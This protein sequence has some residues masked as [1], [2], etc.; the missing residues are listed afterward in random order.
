MK[1]RTLI[2]AMP[3]VV[4]L[5]AAAG[6]YLRNGKSDDFQFRTDTVK[7]GNISV[8]VTAT[9]TLSAVIT[10]QVGSQVSGN[11]EKLYADF[12]SRVRR[13]QIVAELDTTF[14][15]AA[16][17]EAEAN[18]QRAKVQLADAK[19]NLDRTTVLFTKN[20]VAQLDLDAARTTYEAAS[21][22]VKQMQAQMDRA[23]VNI[24]YA[25]IRSPIDGVVISRNVD[26][27]QTVAASL[28]APVLFSIANDLTKMQV[29]ASVDE[30]DI[31][32]ISVGLPVT[33]TV[34]AY[35]NEMFT[36]TVS[37]VR[38]AP[39]IVQNVVNYTVI[40]DVPNKDLKLMPGMTANVS[41]LVAERDSVVKVP[42]LA[43]TFRPTQ[44]LIDAGLVNLPH[45]PD[46]GSNGNRSRPDRGGM[47]MQG[48]GFGQGGPGGM[49]GP[50]M[51]GPG[52]G[53]RRQGGI[54][55][56]MDSKG[57][58]NPVPVRTGLSD[59]TSTEIVAGNVKPGDKVVLGVID[60]N[61]TAQ[62]PSQNNPF[63]PQRMGGGGGGR[64]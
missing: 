39:V 5:L 56:V 4:I 32:R 38:L 23:R 47:G 43:L 15:K 11:I 9:G 17:N 37:Q 41:V 58:L 49:Q 6:L 48:R 59:G 18:V 13:G 45:R 7:Q 8:V 52:Q 57:T 30:A 20:L 44:S 36:G 27:G 55:W 40:I 60:P 50:G 12:N 54:L 34:D 46:S 51:P 10:V 25:T 63:A 35:P 61:P 14:L 33:F 22:T 64:R 2:I 19:R 24:D 26:V 1:R 3:C 21:A 31:G 16:L 29:Q 62:G 28:Q 42:A 53:Q